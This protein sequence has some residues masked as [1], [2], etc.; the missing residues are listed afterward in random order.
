MSAGTNNGNS[1]QFTSKTIDTLEYNIDK[2]LNFRKYIYLIL[3]NWYW[4]S[5]TVFVSLS[6]A[7]LKTRYTLPTYQ[8]VS[9]LLL[10]QEAGPPD[11]FSQI[12]SVRRMKWQADL[13]NEIAK[14]N[15]FSLH[16]R[17]IDSLGWYALWEGHGRVARVRPLYS[18]IPYK[19]EIDSSSDTWYLDQTFILEPQNSDYI[20]FTNKTSIDTV[21]ALNSRIN[22]NGWKFKIINNKSTP[23]YASYSFVYP[24]INSLTNLFRNK[25]SYV[26]EE[27]LGTIISVLSVGDI[28]ALDVDYINTLCS[29]YI[30]SGLERKQLIAKNT[31]E[32]IDSQIKI[33]QD[34][35]QKSE[36]Q[37]LNFRLQESVVDLAREGQLIYERL[38]NLYER[39]TQH[40]LEKNYYNYIIDYINSKKDPNAIIAP[41]LVNAYDQMFIDQV[42]RLQMLFE[43]RE[44]LSFIVDD[45]N[46]EL[47]QLNIRI[48]SARDRI[49]ETLES[50]ISNINLALGQLELEESVVEKQ[51]LQLPI[52]KQELLSIERKVEV[53]NQFYKFLLEKH[54][55]AGI[56]KASTVSNVRILDKA[57]IY[58]SHSLG[59][60]SYIIYLVAI[61]IGF[62]TP[63]GLIML[64]DQFDNRIKDRSD[65]EDQTNIPIIGVVTHDKSKDEIPVH[66]HPRSSFSE[67]FR[68]IRTNLGFILK[69]PSSKIIMVTSAISDE[70]KTFIAANLAA[71]LALNNKKTILAGFDLRRP[72]LHKLFNLQNKVGL[73]SYLTGNSEME[74]II[75]G[76]KIPNMDVM[77]AGPIPPNPAEL[78][79]SSRMSTIIREV[80]E[81][82]DYVVI[83][84]PPV[85]LV[86]D[87]FLI[88]QYTHANIFV[89]RQNYSHKGV[90][91][92]INN[93]SGIKIK[94]LSILVNDIKESSAFGYRYYYGYGYGYS[95]G[96]NYYSK[97]GQGYYHEDD[98]YS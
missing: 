50:L 45:N 81:A 25:I 73:S 55:E 87:A 49:I 71:V 5:I 29:N 27:E 35:L 37:L 7:F 4:F 86:T 76:T 92:M 58:T 14:L 98:N 30:N 42:F 61:I 46:P 80:A 9:T 22:L 95:H 3:S 66:V 78:I 72:S 65:I 15:A 31:L 28:V 67:S 77:I 41:T 44:K 57:S 26:A 69:E 68:Q 11:L 82:Y 85:A 33:I 39:K 59:T 60:K 62:F 94:N 12:R 83:D 52:S 38:Q 17:T 47:K 48:V 1:N 13:A 93:V 54:A 8:V 51:L 23:G 70:G 18:N 21:I 63:L 91:E 79:G 40:I 20:A 34:T 10:E 96:Y 43:D 36:K 75:S 53:N 90:L 19:I 2:P 56:Q 32:F 97:Y 64:I 24:N 84:T 88:G 16:Q 6:V 89:I 74:D